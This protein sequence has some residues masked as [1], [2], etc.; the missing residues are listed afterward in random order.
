MRSTGWRRC[1]DSAERVIAEHDVPLRAVL[2]D[3]G[4]TLLFL[5]YARMA[6]AVGAALGLPLT[7]AALAGRCGRARRGRWSGPRVRTIAERATAYLEALFL[8]AGVPAERLPEVRDCLGR[9]CTASGI[10]GAAPRERYARGARAAPARPDS[11]RRGVE[12][13]RPGRARRS[14]RPGCGDYFDVVID[15]APGRGGEARSRYL[16]GRAR[17]PR[18]RRRTRRCTSATSTRWTWSARVPR[19][20]MPCC[21]C[22]PAPRGRTECATVGSLEELAD[23][24]L[25]GETRRMTDCALGRL[26]PRGCAS[27]DPGAGRQARPRRP[28]PRRQGRG[29]RAA[30][31]RHGGG[32]HRPAPDAGDDRDRRG[33]GGRGRGRALDPLRRAHD[34]LPAGARSCC[35]EMGRPDMLVTGGGIIPPRTWTR[36]QQQG[37]GQLFGPGHAHLRSHRLHRVVGRRAPRAL[38]PARPAAGS[39]SSPTNTA[40][41]AA[42]LREG[43]GAARVAKMHEQG[44][45]SPRERVARLLDPGHALARARPARRLRPVRRPGAR[46]GRHHRRRRGRGPRGRGRRQRRDGEGRLVV[47]R[48]HHA[49]FCARRK[50]RC[51]SGSRSSI[52]WTAPA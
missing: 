47:A 36:S 39:A 3:A 29:R 12:Q 24:L 19:G 33:A 46:R 2:F 40:Q 16:P 8:E 27:P 5:D 42:R 1:C 34:A 35:D 50:S 31:R 41:L 13:R 37:I 21:S 7:G 51:A 9:T 10:S 23:D 25:T 48:D 32:V 20:S 26:R 11:A 4:N 38:S 18:R 45:L 43:G 52:W 30:R 22:R 14:R 17:R 28:R 6:A 49:R 44:K 15:S